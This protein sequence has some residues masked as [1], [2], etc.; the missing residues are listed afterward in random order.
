MGQRE[1]VFTVKQDG[2]EPFPRELF[3]FYRTVHH[4]A[5]EKQSVEADGVSQLAH[6]ATPLLRNSS[7]R[8][9]IYLA[10]RPL[11]GIPVAAP[12]LTAVLVTTEEIEA[13]QCYGA[14]RVL[15]RLGQVARA[16]PFPPWNDRG[17][18]PVVRGDE[19]ASAE[20]SLRRAASAYAERGS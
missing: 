4:L 12:Y 7:F 6:D 1:L 3:S 17:R 10:P 18:Q 11:A 9:V 2:D 20:R 16:F 8:G 15:A 19:H 5:S 13:A 14:A